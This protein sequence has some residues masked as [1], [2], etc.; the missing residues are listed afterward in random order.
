MLSKRTR[1]IS[2]G[3]WRFDFFLFTRCFPCF[4]GI[5]L[6]SSRWRPLLL[7]CGPFALTSKNVSKRVKRSNMQKATNV[8]DAETGGGCW[9]F[10]RSGHKI[11]NGDVAYMVHTVS[12]FAKRKTKR[13]ETVPVPHRYMSAFQKK[14]RKRGGFAHL[15]SSH[16]DF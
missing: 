14:K 15:T 12:V 3:L 6:Q 5:W 2:D 16:V 11:L 13:N 8:K 4:P 1:S 10:H 7:V 9:R